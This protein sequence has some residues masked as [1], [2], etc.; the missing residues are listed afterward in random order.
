MDN[1]IK[2][3]KN[4][5]NDHIMQEKINRNYDIEELLDRSYDSFTINK[6][7]IRLERPQIENKDRKTY[8]LNFDLLCNSLNRDARHVEAYLTKELAIATSR[9]EGGKLKIDKVVRKPLV[10][11]HIKDY[12]KE[13]I[14]CKSCKSIKTHMIKENRINYMVCDTCHCKVSK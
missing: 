4:N 8:I 10:E 1:D 5:S 3:S 9:K 7:K 12:I 14:Q 11:G 13:Y 6:G 2:E